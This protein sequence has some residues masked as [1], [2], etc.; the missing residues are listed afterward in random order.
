LTPAVPRLSGLSDAEVAER[1]ARGQ[2]N[3]FVHAAGRSAW[4]IV[5][6]NAFTV[7]N[8]TLFATLAATLALG[9]AT[10]GARGIVLGDTLFA[11]GSV[12]LNLVVGI[13]QE[14]RAKRMLDRLAALSVRRV[15]ARRN[16]RAVEVAV[17]EIVRD[18]LVELVPG[19]RAPVD[20][21]L[22][23]GR[24]LEMD[25]SLL[26]GESDSVRKQ[27]GD[28]IESGSFCLAG[29]GV[30]RAE[31]IGGE[32]FANRLTTTA[33]APKSPLTPLQRNINFIVQ[34]L[35]AVMIVI[36]VLQIVA[37]ANTGV[38]AVDALRYTL[39]IITTFVPAGLILA[40]TVSLTVAAV[41]IGRAGTLVQRLPAIEGIANVTVL[42]VDKTGTLTTNRLTVERI[43]PLGRTDEAAAHEL[44][45]RYVAGI[46][47]PNRTAQAIAAHV[48]APASPPRVDAEVPF[49]SARKWGAVTLTPLGAGAAPETLVLGSPEI[50]LDGAPDGDGEGLA[51]AAQFARQG[52]RVVA[53]SRASSHPAAPSA[54]SDGPPGP[55][56]P[57]GLA[58]IRDE[59]RPDIAATIGALYARGV[60][61][62]VISGDH[63]ET[64][65]AVATCAAIADGAVLTE[66]ELRR[67][68]D[69]AFDAAVRETT[70]FARIA[71]DTKRRIVASLTG[72]GEYVAMVGDGVNDVPALK[73]ARLGIAMND[74]AQIAKDVSDLVLLE[75]TLSTLPR[76]LDEGRTIAQKIYTSARLYLTR[77]AV[78]VYAI[79]L[80]GFAGLAFA[81]EPRQISWNATVTVV[82]PCM[83]LAFG[84]TRPAHTRSFARGVLGYSLV[85]GMVGSVVVVAAY[86]LDHALTGRLP[87]ARTVFALTNLH[88]A[89][90]VLWDAH[91]VSVLSPASVG[92]HPRV[93]LLGAVLL[94]VGLA[95]PPL[96][97]RAFNAAPLGPLEWLLVLVLPLIGRLV[98]R[99]YGPFV[100]GMRR[101]L[102]TGQ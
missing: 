53:L 32:S 39:V 23:E 73:S 28:W 86:I 62:K 40:I 102:E 79:V 71:P 35:V 81:G 22:V 85:V 99:V 91:G 43:V 13:V 101:I 59:L 24:G 45:G 97:P 47:A 17:E 58:V 41:R 95:A 68:S 90:H 54:D 29:G 65:R 16:G 8:V 31:K 76:A 25:E 7:F 42:C 51:L 4:D 57:V 88:F 66:P 14:L 100:R 3:A 12:W 30:L 75:N 36:A 84:V 10:P 64:V 34:C 61:V 98:M 26:T 60:A 77:N 78:T 15:R 52:M 72:Q 27:V 50:L 74:G 9:L 67:L 93:T 87:H 48:G 89:I 18:D 80:A 69:H 96:W 83:L 37:A 38:P 94:A 11:G 19:D 56:T 44:F 55:R 6:D 82:L 49:S 70:L 20:G 2:T 92:R 5:R 46:T 1:V 63:P 33:R 21:P